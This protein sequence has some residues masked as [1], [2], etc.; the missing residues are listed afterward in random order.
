MADRAAINPDTLG[1]IRILDE[2]PDAAS[3]LMAAP[4]GRQFVRK[5]M[6]TPLLALRARNLFTERLAVV[7]RVVHPNLAPLAGGGIHKRTECFTL[8]PYAP[9][10]SLLDALVLGDLR[11]WA[12]PLPP[13]DAMRMVY[14][15][16]EGVQALHNQRI[17]HGRTA[18]SSNRHA[19]HL[20][21]CYLSRDSVYSHT[22]QLR[23]QSAAQESS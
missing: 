3:W 10:R 4:D 9:R 8:I 12:L 6:A 20:R 11:L 21:G 5:V 16:A 13:T 19:R 22:A 7:E 2:R 23:R 17:L 18:F 1:T 15:I 14:E